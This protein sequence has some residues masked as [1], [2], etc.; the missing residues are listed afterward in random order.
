M[1]EIWKSAIGDHEMLFKKEHLKNTMKKKA[2]TFI[3]EIEKT[4]PYTRED[5]FVCDIEVDI[6]AFSFADILVAANKIS[7][8]T[9]FVHDENGIII[10]RKCFQNN[11]FSRL[12]SMNSQEVA[13]LSGYRGV[14][15]TLALKSKIA[16]VKYMEFSE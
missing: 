14:G 13:L 2:F 10:N 8:A 1:I 11:N 4:H 5:F 15:K 16:N 9:N 12:F 6:K 7:K 3:C